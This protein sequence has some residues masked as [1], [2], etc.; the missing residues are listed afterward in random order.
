MLCIIILTDNIYLRSKIVKLS[1][2]EKDIVNNFKKKIEKKF[3]EEI[4]SV[5]VFGSKARGDAVRDSDIDIL[6][7]TKSDNKELTRKIRFLGY[8]LEIENNVVLS[9]QVFLKD[10]INY[11]RTL[12]TQFIRNVD[13]DSIAI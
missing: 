2:K 5:I 9:I 12:P 1:F 4:I 7:I 11:L 3:P 6:V 13:R 8:D 10:Y